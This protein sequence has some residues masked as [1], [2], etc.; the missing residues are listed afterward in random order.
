M[1]LLKFA[2]LGLINRKPITGYDIAKE[3]DRGLVNF[4]YATHSQIYPELRRLTEE[5][6]VTFEIDTRGDRQEKKRYLITEKG[7]RELRKWFSEFDELESTP[8]DVFR[9]KLYFLNETDKDTVFAHF[10]D[11]LQKRS[12][13]LKK[14][15]Q[16]LK[17]KQQASK[18]Y[19]KTYNREI[20]DY[21]VVY[22]AIAREKGYIDWI[23]YCIDY[24]NGIK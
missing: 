10:R 22:G 19:G 24:L 7:K 20:G 15:E 8:K 9:L 3:F 5:G 16:G 23:N 21:L 11:Q 2:I 1:R 6:L 18:T 13:K 4:W 14:L 17:E 12:R